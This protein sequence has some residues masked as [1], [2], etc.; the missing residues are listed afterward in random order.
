[1]KL[2]DGLLD[3][4]DANGSYTTSDQNITNEIMDAIYTAQDSVL[5]EKIQPEDAGAEI[6]KVVDSYKANNQ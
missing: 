3:M 6:Q 4:I 5:L 2:A 1:M